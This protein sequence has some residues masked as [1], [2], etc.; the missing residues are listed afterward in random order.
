MNDPFPIVP[1]DLIKA[2][3]GRFPDRCPHPDWSD[4]KIWMAVGARKV[5]DF[6]KQQNTQQ[7]DN[8]LIGK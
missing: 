3:D 8:I 1:D 4:R 2:L 6:L 7:N 5:V